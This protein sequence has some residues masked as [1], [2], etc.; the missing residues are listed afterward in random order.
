[1]WVNPGEDL[2]GDGAVFDIDDVNSASDDANV[3]S[4]D[5]I[6]W[7]FFS[8]FGSGSGLTVMPGEDAG[9]P[10]NNPNDF[11]GHGT[12]VAGCVA[13]VTNNEFDVAGVA[14]GW[15]G[16]HR[17]Y[18]GTRLMC[19][20]AG[21]Q[22]DDGFG[23]VNS[24]NASQ[25]L[26]Y[27]VQNGAQ[28]V[29]M[30]FGMT[31]MLAASLELAVL[32][33]LPLVHAGGNDA[34]DCP[35]ALDVEPNLLMISVAATDE[36]DRATS[37]TNYGDWIDVSAPGVNIRA[38][39]SI[40]YTPGVSW[41]AGTSFAAPITSAV[42]ALI[43][44]TN[45]AMS[46]QFADSVLVAAVV[47]I[48]PQNP[49]KEGLLGS[50]RVSPLKA[51]TSLGIAR[52]TSSETDGQVPHAVTFSDQSPHQP[53]D[54]L[55]EFG[56]G[57]SSSGQNPMHTYI[58]PGLYSVTLTVQDTNGTGVEKL[59]RYVWAQAD[60]LGFSTEVVSP[61]ETA[62]IAV[63][64][65]NTVPV[66]EIRLSFTM[67]NDHEILPY[68]LITEG[69]RSSGFHSVNFTGYSGAGK[70]YA[71]TMLASSPTGSK[72]LA[73]G[74][75]TLLYID[76]PIEGDVPEGTVVSVDTLT[77]SSYSNRFTT[78]VGEYVPEAYDGGAMSIGA[79][80]D[81]FTGNVDGSLDGLVDVSDILYLANTVFLGGPAVA[82]RAAGNVDGDPACVLD[83]SDI[84][85]LASAV[86]LGGAP[87][88]ACDNVN[89]IP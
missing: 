73:P 42:S 56:D 44:S 52:F 25:A 14:G 45:P 40:A 71:V 1:V 24:L 22:A 50:G 32:A 30:S 83:V 10:D 70:K 19:L 15:T 77:W 65:A 29:N 11:D 81:G 57:G 37:F 36:Q 55:W 9:T 23:Y 75:G 12:S 16:D 76:I 27:A 41:V 80:C 3:F 2:D 43:R 51:V 79:C 84:L 78:V 5:L 62:R 72:V 46:R 28:I 69:T 48:D 89:C 7:D 61:G 49:G 17:S 68:Y 6:G 86:F 20:R 4:D 18:R 82:C 64:Y 85:W 66:S 35:E 63:F 31:G 8:G 39:N 26:D 58:D 59:N 47:D 33:G 87:P 60:S 53:S 13:A 38:L 54:W 74:S 21:A 88:S 34:C 67:P